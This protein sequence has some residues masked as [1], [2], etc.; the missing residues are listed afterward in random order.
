MQLC[1]RVCAERAQLSHHASWSHPALATPRTPSWEHEGMVVEEL[2]LI[3][4]G[5]SA[6]GLWLY[7]WV[8]AHPLEETAWGPAVR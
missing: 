3:A 4:G 1:H 7:N 5:S 2:P 8:L 6:K